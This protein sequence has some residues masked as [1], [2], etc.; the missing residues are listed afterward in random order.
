VDMD[1]DDRRQIRVLLANAK[2]K[3]TTPA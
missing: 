1:V 3:S 2:V